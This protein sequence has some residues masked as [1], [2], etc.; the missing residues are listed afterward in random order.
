MRARGWGLF[1][2]YLYDSWW[3]WWVFSWWL[4]PKLDWITRADAKAS[5]RTKG[6]QPPLSSNQTWCTSTPQGAAERT[7]AV[8]PPTVNGTEVQQKQTVSWRRLWQWWD[9]CLACPYPWLSGVPSAQC[10]WW[11]SWLPVDKTELNQMTKQD[12][13][14][15]KSIHLSF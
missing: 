10:F 6:N 13:V 5:N 1:V 9:T 15:T 7:S 11:I 8:M 12:S 3:S 14:S 4:F 2:F